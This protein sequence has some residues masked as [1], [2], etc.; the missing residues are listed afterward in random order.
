M[1]RFAPALPG[2]VRLAIILLLGGGVVACASRPDPADHA[3]VTAFAAANDPL[4]PLNR[5]S[6]GITYAFDTLALRP[7]AE[8]YS[9]LVPPVVRTG[10]HNAL[11]NLRSPVIL[12][13]NLPQGDFEQAG[14]TLG[15]A[16]INTTLGI[17][18]LLDVAV[19]FGLPGRNE[20]FGQTL[21]IWGVAEGP[22]LFVPLLGPSNPRDLGGFGVD[23]AADP[24][25]WI[26]GA[27]WVAAARTRAGLTALDT[28]EALLEPV[29]TMMLTTT[30]PHVTIREVYRQRR[31]AAIAGRGNNPTAAAGT[32]FGVAMGMTAGEMAPLR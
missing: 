24:L 19:D 7:A 32:G 9:F 28:R 6:L 18:G 12:A 21:A 23:V 4:Q 14:A 10:L 3:A 29:D 15:R 13:N 17:G 25:T 22:Y 1:S 30:D 8:A 20:D 27:A 16:L 11:G 31:A 26:G 5:V 2:V